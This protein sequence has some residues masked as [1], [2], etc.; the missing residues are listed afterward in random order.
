MIPDIPWRW[1]Y[2]SV[3]GSDVSLSDPGYKR[4][5]VCASSASMYRGLLRKRLDNTAFESLLWAAVYLHR[6]GKEKE[7]SE[8]EFMQRNE[9]DT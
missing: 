2:K 9:T 1:W 8:Q 6:H 4:P 5:C 7:S 3:P